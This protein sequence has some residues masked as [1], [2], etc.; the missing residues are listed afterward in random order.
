[1]P[2]LLVPLVLMFLLLLS[3][4]RAASS[5]LRWILIWGAGFLGGGIL[6]W[7]VNFFLSMSFSTPAVWAAGGFLGLVVLSSLYG[8]CLEW[9]FWLSRHENNPYIGTVTLSADQEADRVRFAKTL[10]WPT[11]L[12]SAS[13]GFVFALALFPLIAGNQ[14]TWPTIAQFSLLGGVSLAVQGLL[15]G[16]F[17]G[18]KRSRVV[19]DPSRHSLGE[20]VGWHLSGEHTGSRAAC[21]WGLGYALHQ[22]PAGLIAGLVLGVLT[23]LI[24]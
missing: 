20:Y 7:C 9:V 22:L 6:A 11:A 24:I 8:M 16:V 21:G 12:A 5:A 23:N 4:S 14:S 3:L 10:H 2:I 15:L 13:G 18:F 1:M 19:F 17:L